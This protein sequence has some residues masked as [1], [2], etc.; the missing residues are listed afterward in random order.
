MER[1]PTEFKEPLTCDHFDLEV[2]SEVPAYNIMDAMVAINVP[3]KNK[4][5]KVE[6]TEEESS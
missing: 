5:E 2:V 1:L 3:T 6:D 4:Q